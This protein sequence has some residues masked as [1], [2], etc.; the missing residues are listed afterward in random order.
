MKVISLNTC[1]GVLR[2]P[3][4]DFITREGE[5]TDIFC[6]QEMYQNDTDIVE[7]ENTRTNLY[8]E[9][10]AALPDF[11]GKFLAVVEGKGPDSPEDPSIRGGLAI[12][13]KRSYSVKYGSIFVAGAYN[14]FSSE[15]SHINWPVALQYAEIASP[16]GVVVVAHVHGLSYPGHKL[17]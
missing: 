17:D 4:M 12:F 2:T 10:A 15:G 6:F 3:L 11:A 5:S 7:K 1:G 16:G 14:T 13:I 9:I 8:T